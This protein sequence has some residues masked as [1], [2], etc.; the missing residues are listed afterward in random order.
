MR[1]AAEPFAKIVLVGITAGLLGVT[2]G[3]AATPP[4]QPSA[5]GTTPGD[6]KSD[7]ST[8]PAK[9]QDGQYTDQNGDPT[10]HV[11]DAG[12]KVDWYT[13]SGYL[14]YSANC[15][16]CHGP[17][18]MGSTYAPSLVDAL[19]GM[20]YAQF[21]GIVVGGKKDVNAAQELVMPAFGD[22]RNVMCYMPDIYTY[23]RARAEGALGRNRPPEHEP[24]PAAFEKAEDACMK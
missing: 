2:P 16:V 24:K 10:Y 19:K 21:A 1:C 5:T 4:T 17:D 18:G 3:A 11:T 9:V 23:L 6:L 8:Q 15:I 13:M 7:G 20:S 14:R 22:N 12:K